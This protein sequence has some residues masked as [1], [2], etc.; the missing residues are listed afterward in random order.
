ME[1]VHPDPG[2]PTPAGVADPPVAN[3]ERLSFDLKRLG[4]IRAAADEPF[5]SLAVRDV[6][7]YL[8][9]GNVETGKHL[10]V[11]DITVP[12]RPQIVGSCAL[13]IEAAALAATDRHVYVLDEPHLKVIDVSDPTRPHE[14]GAC[15][16]GE[17]LWSLA[18]DGARAYVTDVVSLRVIDLTDPVAPA[19]VGRCE[20]A[21]AQ[22]ITVAD[23]TVFVACDINGMCILNV[24]DP[25]TPRLMAQF[26]LSEGAADVAIAGEIA[27]IAGG[28]DAVTLWIVDISDRNSPRPIARYG[29]WITGSVAI[30]GEHALIAGGD[31]EIVDVSNPSAPRRAGSYP[32]VN[33]VVVRGNEVFALGDIGLSILSR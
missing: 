14:V 25:R 29:D 20:L 13:G 21:D 6:A 28:E 3:P 18:I 33:V 24:A 26:D 27:Y 2:E 1:A 23:T 10:R 31:L 15:E 5:L 11:V 32:D 12:T 7:A 22:G 19:E 16:L 17:N 30:L 4:Q 8:V 9:Q